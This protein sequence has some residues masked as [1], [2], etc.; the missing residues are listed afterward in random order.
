M[1]TLRWGAG[2]RWIRTSGSAGTATGSEA[3]RLGLRDEADRLGLSTEWQENMA[4][5]KYEV[6]RSAHVRTFEITAVG[7]KLAPLINRLA[8]EAQIRLLRSNPLRL[9]M[10]PSLTLHWL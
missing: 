9:G 1:R 8:V 5:A 10:Q 6:I 7:A 2:E 3:I 4:A